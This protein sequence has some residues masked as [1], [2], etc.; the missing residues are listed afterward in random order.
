MNCAA[1][2]TKME[3]EK[4][5]YHELYYLRQLT[6]GTVTNECIRSKFVGIRRTGVGEGS[7]EEFKCRVI[8]IVHAD[9]RP[10]LFHLVTVGIIVSSTKT[11]TTD[12]HKISLRELVHSP[13]DQPLSIVSDASFDSSSYDVWRISDQPTTKPWCDF[14]Y[15]YAN[16]PGRSMSLSSTHPISLVEMPVGFRTCMQFFSHLLATF[17]IHS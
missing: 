8:F 3:F 2:L 1:V 4:P 17:D 14:V 15:A 12:Q 16:Y 7:P 5:F 11:F 9:P 10:G 13:T 6:N